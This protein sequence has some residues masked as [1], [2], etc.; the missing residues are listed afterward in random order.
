[1]AHEVRTP[2]SY[3]TVA[4]Y[5]A[6]VVTLA[7]GLMGLVNP[8][9]SAWLLGLEIVLPRGVG[10]VRSSLGALYLAMGGVMLWAVASRPKGASYLRFAGLLWLA[11]ALGRL[12]SLLIDGGW[13]L[14][15]IGALLLELLLAAAALVASYQTPAG[16]A[17][18]TPV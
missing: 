4:A 8:H 15:S 5:V 17:P 12:L 9:F 1:V 16:K 11:I 2:P 14:I 18:H 13:G 7:L 3:R 6:S 10:E